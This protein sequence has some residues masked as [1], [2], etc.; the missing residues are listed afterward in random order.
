VG[1]GVVETGVV[2]WAGVEEVEVV[3]VLELTDFEVEVEDAL[4][5]VEL[6]DFEELEVEDSA[7]TPPE[8]VDLPLDEPEFGELLELPP[9]PPDALM[10]C[11]D[12]DMSE[13]VYS[14]PHP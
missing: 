2:V 7:K 9:Q 1:E 5:E 10:L 11:H 12:P 8:D 13:Y 3:T 4:E 6:E 14:E